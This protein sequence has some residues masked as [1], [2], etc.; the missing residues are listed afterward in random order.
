VAL[1]R[2]KYDCE[3]FGEED[4]EENEVVEACRHYRRD[5]GR[6]WVGQRLVRIR[7][8]FG[9]VVGEVMAYC[10]DESAPFKVRYMYGG[11]EMLDWKDVSR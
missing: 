9:E 2:V 8:G 7:P 11:E 4:L 5:V 1:W 10:D 3:A 6:Q